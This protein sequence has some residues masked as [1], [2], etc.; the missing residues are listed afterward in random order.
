MSLLSRHKIKL[1]FSDFSKIDRPL[2]F[3]TLLILCFGFLMVY[4]ASVFYASQNFNLKY[5]FLILQV[6]WIGVGLTAAF[7]TAIFDLEFFKSKANLFFIGT[8]VILG[9]ILLPTPFAPE[10]YGARRWFYINPDPLPGVPFLGKVG[11]QPSELAKLVGIIFGAAFFSS[12]KFQKESIEKLSRNFIFIVFFAAFLIAEEPD[13]TT[14]F[15]TAIILLSVAFYAYAPIKTFLTWVGPAFIG[16]ILYAIS[17]PYRMDRIRTLFNPEDVDKLGAGY[18]IRQIMIA[19]GSGGLWG[20][21]FGN[22]R[23]KYAYLPE[24][25]GDSIFAIIGEEFGFLGCVVLIILF[26][27]FI[28]RCFY[29]AERSRTKFGELICKGVGTWFALQALINLLSMVRLM[30]LSGVPLP[31]ISYGGSSTIFMLIGIGLVM[32]VSKDLKKV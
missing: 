26:G 23:Q 28:W 30:P 12:S 4:D 17:S 5:H 15:I 1:R 31:L 21:G 6:G 22:S 32:N 25:I 11:F 14:A 20:L 9:F 18:H 2:L 3:V 16:V 27:C 29:I 19:L 7:V 8:L 13:F 10:I 24:V